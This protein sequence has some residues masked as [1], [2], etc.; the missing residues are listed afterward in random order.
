MN[1]VFDNPLLIS[2]ILIDLD[3]D[4]II[5]WCRTHKAARKISWNLFFWQQKAQQ[6]FETSPGLF[7]KTKL[8]PSQRY[9]EI[10]TQNKGVAFGSERF[11]SLNKVVR[12]AIRQDRDDIYLYAVSIGF[13]NW[14]LALE[15]FAQKNNTFMIDQ[16]S[17]IVQ[18]DRKWLKM[19]GGALKGGYRKLFDQINEARVSRNFTWSNDDWIELVGCAAYPCDIDFYDNFYKI[20]L[21]RDRPWNIL[22]G[23]V[24]KGNIK[25]FEH[26]RG[27]IQRRTALGYRS[28]PEQQQY[29]KLM[30]IAVENGRKEMYD[31]LCSLLSKI[32]SLHF[33]ITKFV[34]K[35]ANKDFLNHVIKT[36]PASIVDWNYISE[37]AVQSGNKDFV[38]YTLS[39]IKSEITWISIIEASIE[40]GQKYIFDYL[41]TLHTPTIGEWEEVLSMYC[42]CE[43]FDH[44][45]SRKPL[46]VKVIWNRILSNACKYDYIRKFN[47][48]ISCLPPDYEINWNEIAHICEAEGSEVILEYIASLDPDVDWDSL[49][50]LSITEE[51]NKIFLHIMKIYPNYPYDWNRLYALA[52]DIEGMENIV[53]EFIKQKL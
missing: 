3:Y 29:L 16:L 33:D 25:M 12:R 26:I 32:H 49:A 31:H 13:D 10:L 19:A 38:D 48:I 24:K 23:P 21:S 39:F 40:A 27:R 36:S 4:S 30:K 46:N 34:A 35:H 5:N 7:Q 8:G 41:L 15:K 50:Y 52:V 37:G 44:L 9:L 28:G 22:I 11:I 14:L 47:H 18:S 53:V 45:M 17:K 20:T 6:D 2:K 43:M 42:S 1:P 51:N